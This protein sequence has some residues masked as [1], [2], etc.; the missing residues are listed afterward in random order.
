MQATISIIIVA[1]SCQT[2][3]LIHLHIDY[4]FGAVIRTAYG[5][6]DG[7]D[8]DNRGGARIA[9]KL[10]GCCAAKTT[11]PNKNFA[12]RVPQ[13]LLRPTKQIPLN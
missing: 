8:E 5:N 12:L 6:L 11:P 10:G 9:V 1:L 2:F 7:V 13:P 3:S 4:A